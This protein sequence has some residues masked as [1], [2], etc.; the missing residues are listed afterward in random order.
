MTGGSGVAEAALFIGWGA[1]VRGREAKGLQVFGEGAQYFG[2]L[3]QD[4]AIEGF[5][6][7]VLGPHGGDL[8]G[9]FLLRASAAQ[10]DA[11]RARD[12]FFRLTARAGLVVERLGV[13]PA[14]VDEAVQQQLVVYQE[15]IQ[16]LT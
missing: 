4:G 14:A 3:Q 16:E 7:V 8:Y 15:A 12:D 2:Q 11:L 10:L 9:F 5:D 6:T 1:P 13:V